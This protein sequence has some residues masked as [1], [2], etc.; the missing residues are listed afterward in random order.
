MANEQVYRRWI[1]HLFE[2]GT[3]AGL[4]EGQLLERFMAQGDN[5]ALEALVERHGPM[6]LGVC[7]RRLGS[8]HDVDDAFQATFLILIRKA[9]A[10]RDYHRLGP[11]LHGVA[12]RVSARARA[13]AAR[14]HALEESAARAE[15]DAAAQAPDGLAHQAEICAVIDEEIAR[16]PTAHRTAI[17]LCDLQGQTQHD[18]ARLLGWSEGALRGRLA[19][20]RQ[21]L[22]DQL[23]RRGVAPSFL[24]TGASLPH[25][26]LITTVPNG[27]MEATTRAAAATLLAGRAAPSTATAIS[28]SVAALVQGVIRT[29]TISKVAAVASAVTVAAASLLILGGLVQAGL[30]AVAYNP[31]QLAATKA[32]TQEPEADAVRENA[33][34]RTLDFRVVGR[35]K[36]QAIAGVTVEISYWLDE[37]P[38]ETK[39]TTDDQGHC[40]IELPRNAS[41]V[42]AFCGKDGFVPAKQAWSEEEN[43]A[44]LPAT[45]TQ[46]LESGLPIGGLVRD[47]EGTPVAGAEVIVAISQGKSDQPDLDVPSPGNGSVYAPFP[48]FRVKTDAQGRWRCSI[49]PA[50]ADQGS[51]LLFL[52]KHDDYVSDTGGYARRLSLKTARLM[53][54]ALVMK[55]GLHVAGQVHDG[56]GRFVA[57]ATVV[58]AYSASSGNFLRTTTDVAGRFAFPHADDASGLGRWSVSV[59]AAGFAPAWKMVVPKGEIPFLD[60][61]LPLAKPVRGEVIDNEGRPV[62]GAQVESKW[63]ECYFLDWKAV[64]DADGRFVWLGGPTEG[65]IE[66]TVRKNGFIWAVGRRI[67]ALA[68]GVKITINPSIQARGTVIDAET[69]EPIPAF[70]VIEGE[71]LGNQR[72]FWRSRNGTSATDGHFDVSPFTMD[73]PGVAFFIQIEADGY[74]PASSR[75]IIPGEKVVDLEFKLKKGIGPTGIVRLPDGSPAIGADVYLNS[76][77]YG[78]PLENNQQRFLQLGDGYWIKTDKQGHFTFQP[79]DEA[80]GV[81]VLH[82]KGVAQKSPTEL[83]RSNT[84]TLEPFG[85]IEGI[86]RVG[87]T[88]G[89][90]ENIRVQLDRSVYARDHQFQFFHYTAQTDDRG[91]FVI[92]DVM[93]GEALVFR[94]VNQPSMG[95]ISLIAAAPV[96]IE[97]G[98]TVKV[99]IGGQGRPVV[100]KVSIPPHATGS[101][102]LATASGMFRLDQ[103]QMPQPD[104]F[105]NW[106][107]E[108][109]YAYSKQWHHSSEGKAARRASRSYQFLISSDGRFRIDDVSQG[110]YKLTIRVGNPT[111]LVGG[112]AGGV[113]IQG[114]LERDVEVKPI[115]DGHSE[116][117]LDLGSLEMTLEVEGRRQMAVG[118]AAPAFDIKTLDGKPLR[119][120]DFK[121]RFVLLDFWATWCGPCLEQEP[122]L[123]AVYD[124]FGTDDRFAIVSLSLDAEVAAP[125]NHVSK[126]SLKW[127]QG[128]LGQVSSVPERYGVGSIPQIMLIG[129]DGKIVAKDLGGPGIKAAVSE[130]L[131]R[132]P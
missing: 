79:K 132:L 109:R 12:Y 93:P 40:T 27:L 123:Q 4:D 101:V 111:G 37:S 120:A 126:H 74:L 65:E 129:A 24:T 46:E 7:R 60:F 38:H 56:A 13:D 114:S 15:S 69:S 70:R 119:L 78:L 3:S 88:P 14:R 51:R 113:R 25:G 105:M 86:L 102:S 125:K 72:T 100:G 20:A 121:G 124:A 33:G 110:P 128:F 6:V 50:N 11:W 28:A 42:T 117:A 21:K 64:T 1:D 106:D 41:Q 118:D 80:F 16:L 127:S 54:G 97:P 8:Q 75:A 94:T 92:E 90:N 2:H 19:R 85:R 73:Q 96:D 35:S 18:A 57:G 34:V 10:L 107:Q 30:S 58:L 76:P 84:L 83:A 61:R 130:A 77:K 112:A 67:S 48:H 95:P 131:G 52:V 103:P 87:S 122:H 66:F 59:E 22:R 104:G 32:K 115:A 5:S 55:S 108:K 116:E 49:L 62:T 29:M 39:H 68:G 81:M 9:R 45:Y 44:G 36:Q 47:E 71:A 17:V 43:G 98:R 31:P 82:P 89:V 63:Q 23:V 53:T 99:E 91:H 26:D